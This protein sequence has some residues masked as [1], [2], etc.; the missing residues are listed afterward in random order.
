MPLFPT[1]IKQAEPNMK[2]FP[3]PMCKQDDDG[4]I[5]KKNGEGFSPERNLGDNCGT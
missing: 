4:P 3:A 1:S 2:P 5:K